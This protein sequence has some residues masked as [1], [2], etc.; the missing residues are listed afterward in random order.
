MFDNHPRRTCRGTSPSGAQILQQRIHVKIEIFLRLCFKNGAINR[1]SH[2]SGSTCLVFQQ[3]LGSGFPGAIAL[4]CL[5]CRRQFPELAKFESTCDPPFN[6]VLLLSSPSA[7]RCCSLNRQFEGCFHQ[8][9]PLFLQKL[10]DSFLPLPYGTNPPLGGLCNN[11]LG[12]KKNN[13]HPWISV[14]SSWSC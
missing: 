8:C 4:Q 9:D 10:V 14:V 6:R 5:P 1:G 13:F 12:S 2:H 11:I 3:L 7:T